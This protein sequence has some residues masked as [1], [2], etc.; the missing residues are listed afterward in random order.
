VQEDYIENMISKRSKDLF[1]DNNKSSIDHHS[2]KNG[3]KNI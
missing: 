1:I 2:R 3:K